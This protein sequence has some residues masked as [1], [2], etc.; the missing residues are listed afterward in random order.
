MEPE[1][2]RLPS[3]RQNKSQQKVA[4][5][6]FD[7][8]YSLNITHSDLPF[9]IGRS[10]GCDLVVSSEH[11][12][13]THCRL[14]MAGGELQIVDQ[15]TNGTFIDDYLLKHDNTAIEHRIHVLFGGEFMLVINPYDEAG[16]ELR[17]SRRGD[18][19]VSTESNLHGICLVDICDST[20]KTPDEVGVITQF[21]RIGMLKKNRDKLLMIKNTGDGFLLV[22]EDA[23][24]VV[25]TARAVLHYQ[26]E[27]GVEQGF[28][29]RVTLDAGMTSMTADK[30]RLGLAINRASRIEKVQAG[31]IEVRGQEFE[32]LRARNRCI[33]TEEMRKTMI[34]EQQGR[35]QHVGACKLKGFGDDMHQIFQYQV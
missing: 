14:E 11:V 33:V 16:E 4:R 12:S 5:L 13:R 25:E 1:L 24:C 26:G 20:E 10:S 18:T 21:L 22:Y 7:N 27:R 3:L 32:Q 29:L 19:L 34:T 6:E 8:G 23:R 30:D 31:N 35:C 9:T 15:S 28:D 2:V 17:Q